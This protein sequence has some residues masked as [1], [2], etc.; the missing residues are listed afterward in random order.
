LLRDWFKSSFSN[1]HQACVE[2]CL[3][4]DVVSIRDS[5]WMP[6]GD[7]QRPVITLSARQWTAW[8]D[9]L[10]VVGATGCP[11]FDVVRDG[12][13]ISLRSA[14]NAATLHF[15]DAEWDA[16]MLGVSEGQFDHPG[17]PASQHA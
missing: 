16:F 6:Q 8:L 5:K 9:Q 2:V 15:Y 14:T 7:G 17:R 11:A 4:L 10:R 12:M 13:Q 3:D 1:G